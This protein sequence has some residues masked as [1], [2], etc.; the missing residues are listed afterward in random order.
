MHEP[1]EH[2]EPDYDG[3]HLPAELKETLHAPTL[4]EPITQ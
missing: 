4:R 2:Y 3:L 1:Q